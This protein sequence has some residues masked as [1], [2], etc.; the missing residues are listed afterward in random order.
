M[1]LIQRLMDNFKGENPESP[2]DI[3]QKIP[4]LSRYAKGLENHIKEQYLKISVVGVDP[5]ALLSE[6]LSPECLP[7]IEVSDLLSYLVLE[8]SHYTNKQFKALKV[9]RHIIKWFLALSRQLMERKS[10][11]S[12]L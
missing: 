3:L 1:Q 12:M 9:F 4:V 11:T 7:P 5:V 10:R 2:E 6:Q 8:T